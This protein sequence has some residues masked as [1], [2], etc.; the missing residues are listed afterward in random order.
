MNVI[1]KTM[2]IVTIALDE[3]DKIECPLSSILRK[4]IR[5]ARLRSDYYNLWWLEFE[6][7]SYDNFETKANLLNEISP[8]FT[9]EQFTSSQNQIHQTYF[10]ER[11]I[12]ALSIPEIEV[13]LEHAMNN[14]E[15]QMR[16]EFSERPLKEY[17]EILVKVRQR[18]YEYLSKVE[19]QL[20]FGQLSSDFFE[21]NRLYVDSRLREI[22]PEALEQFTIG[23]R[24]ITERDS[25]SGSHA[26]LSC[27]RLLK[28]FADRIYPAK[29]EPV[30]GSDGSERILTDDKYI[31]R[32]WQFIYEQT[33][34][35]TSGELLLTLITDLGNRVDGVYDLCCK[36]VHADV[37]E[38]EIGQCMIQAYLLIGDILR[39]YDKDSK[40]FDI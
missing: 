14:P 27:R 7:L 11:K 37:S 8:H 21:K 20:V 16:L 10:L 33:K 28:S 18:V 36:G 23:Y 40:S 31:A 13:K 15:T 9:K 34:G 19:K 29:S 2:E 5:I 17:R 38:Y 26:L 6:M 30:K 25:E 12:C 4:A 3:I 35:S 39:L 24:R 22:A 32:L 1:D